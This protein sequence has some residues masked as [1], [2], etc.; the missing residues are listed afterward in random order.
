VAAVVTLGLAGCSGSGAE[1]GAEAGAPAAETTTAA[2][3]P[4]DA[5]DDPAAAKDVCA[6]LTKELP[7]I[8]AVGSE[9]GAMAQ[10]T[11]SLANFYEDHEKVADGTVLDAQTEKTCPEVRA[12]MLKAAGMKSFADF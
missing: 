9:V 10:L 12:E 3:K 4:A 5:A 7:R 11:V 2:D 8:K 6:H 1:E